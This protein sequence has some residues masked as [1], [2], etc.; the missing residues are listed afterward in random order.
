[1]KSVFVQ[2]K[3]AVLNRGLSIFRY[4]IYEL[5]SVFCAEEF[6]AVVDRWLD[7]ASTFGPVSWANFA[8]LF[9]ELQC[10]DH[11]DGF[12]NATAERQVVD[13]LVANDAF[14]VDE[15]QTAKGD[16]AAEQHVVSAT[17]VFVQV[18]DQRIL[19]VAD[20]AFVARHVAPS[21]VTEVTIDRAT[22]K[23]DAQVG[24]L[25]VAV[26]KCD[27]L[28][29]ADECEIQRIKEQQ[30]ILTT[31]I[32]QANFLERT[33]GHDCLCFEFRCFLSYQYTH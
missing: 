2:K 8:V 5:L 1:M 11:A 33:V 6:F 19:N 15:E 18:G 12:A 7:G 27:D 31:V 28:R 24:E 23:L 17:D 10:F 32:A 25:L 21:Q 14:G 13:N 22:E 26:R 30:Y 4:S 16:A 9:D 20:A 29:R 3:P